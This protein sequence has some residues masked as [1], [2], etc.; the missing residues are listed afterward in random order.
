M[1]PHYSALSFQFSKG[2]LVILKAN[3]VQI[4]K[5]VMPIINPRTCPAL[6]HHTS[7]R[8]EQNPVLP[9]CPKLCC[10]IH[11]VQR[12]R[13][14]GDSSEQSLPLERLPSAACTIVQ[15]MEPD[16]PTPTSPLAF[17][18]TTPALRNVWQAL[19]LPFAMDLET[20]PALPSC[21]VLCPSICLYCFCNKVA[22]HRAQPSEPLTRS[23]ISRNRASQLNFVHR[24]SC[25]RVLGTVTS[26]PW[27]VI[28]FV[29]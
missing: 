3:S 21:H 24:R 10:E 19:C 20:S 18:T 15:L 7:H 6:R 8:R 22:G 14:T 28:I 17:P 27:I 9:Q 25:L 12:R 1:W 5:L 11:T 26:T 4:T 2:K 29:T 13:V 16:R 23:T